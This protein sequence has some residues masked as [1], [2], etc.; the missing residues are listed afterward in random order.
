MIATFPMYDQ[1]A[2]QPANDALWS[3]V[4]DALPF[5]APE[6]LTRSDDLMA[7]WTAPDLLLGHT[8]GLV[9]AR[10]L[11]GRVQ[12]VATPDFG[13]EGCPPGHYRS[14][15]VHREGEAPAAGARLAWNDDQSQS[16]WGAAQGY[17]FVPAVRTGAHAQSLAAVESGDADVALID[18]HT[19]TILGLPEGLSVAALTSPTPAPPLITARAEW[20][21]P[22][23]EALVSAFAALPDDVRTTL[24]LTGFPVLDVAQY[25]AVPQPPAP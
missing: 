9:L 21:A 13:I 1:P 7:L 11:R 17:G 25:Y 22:L 15:L 12:Y 16:G 8:C 19:L 3:L 6:H 18:T 14:A 20:V 23:R 5:S 2:L 4:R 24:R 10:P